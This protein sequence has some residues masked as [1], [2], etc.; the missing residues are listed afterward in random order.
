M[1]YQ[2]NDDNL[3]SAYERQLQSDRNPE[4]DECLLSALIECVSNSDLPADDKLKKVESGLVALMKLKSEKRR[5]D[6]ETGRLLSVENAAY[7]CDQYIGTVL[8]VFKANVPDS[9]LHYCTDM[10]PVALYDKCKSDERLRKLVFTGRWEQVQQAFEGENREQ[11]FAKLQHDRERTERSE[12][13]YI[14]AK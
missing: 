4:Q 7:V 3:R 13:R 14:E 10:I 9:V 8:E 1:S 11:Y 2:I 6:V 12:Q 5:H